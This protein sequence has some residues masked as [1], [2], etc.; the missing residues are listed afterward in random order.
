MSRPFSSSRRRA[1]GAIAVTAFA[2]AAGRPECARAG[3]AAQ[4]AWVPGLELYTLGLKPEDD[5]DASFKKVAAIGYRD[6]ELPGPYGKSAAELRCALDGAGL[7][8]SSA[9]APP[10]PVQ[11]AWDLS[12]DIS[13]LAA[14]MKT[15]GVDYVIAPIPLLPDRIYD[16]L[17]HPPAGFDMPAASRL[18]ASLEIDDWKRTAEFLN[19]KGRALSKHGL[20]LGYHNHGF[21]FVPLPGATNGFHLLAAHTDPKAVCFEFDLGWA[22][23]AGE[24]LLPLFE[25]LGD[26]LEMLH[27]K[28]ISRRATSAMDLASADA[29]AGM[30]DWEEV[31]RLVRRCRSIRHMFVEQEEPFPKTPLDSARVDYEFFTR[32]FAGAA[33]TG[34]RT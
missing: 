2:A 18:F 5:L 28:D 4:I 12:G 13:R 34:G 9:H 29:G 10:R 27:L 33:A 26:R 30:V 31:A 19:E 22:V 16:V 7:R 1:L 24:P 21:E 8:S 14:D 3:E 6:V 17:R 23:S 15:L 20:R 11:G 32:L 25:L